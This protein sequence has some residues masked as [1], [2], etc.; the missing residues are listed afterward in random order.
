MSQYLLGNIIKGKYIY[1]Y[2]RIIASIHP[3]NIYLLPIS[4]VMCCFAEF[5]VAA[6]SVAAFGI[7][8]GLGQV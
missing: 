3:L 7:L 8:S 5:A 4:S 6:A 2:I 1:T